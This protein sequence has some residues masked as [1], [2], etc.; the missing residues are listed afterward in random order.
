MNG[1]WL[2]R[3]GNSDPEGPFAAS[4]LRS[5]WSNGIFTDA[6]KL[7]ADGTDEWMPASAIMG[8]IAQEVKPPQPPFSPPSYEQP[9]LVVR[10]AHR[11]ASRETN[12]QSH[13]LTILAIVLILLGTVGLAALGSSALIATAAGIVVMAIAM[14]ARP[15][16]WSCSRCGAVIQKTSRSC[17]TCRAEL[18]FPSTNKRNIILATAALTIGVAATVAL[19]FLASRSWQSPSRDSTFAADYSLKKW[20]RGHYAEQGV[21]LKDFGPPLPWKDYHL[22]LVNI[23]VPKASGDVVVLTLVAEMNRDDSD[24]LYTWTAKEWCKIY[25]T[26]VEAQHTYRDTA[27][28]I[29]KVA[30]SH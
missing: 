6:D 2:S 11:K 4:Q 5:M 16:S 26:S 7:C 20:V 1:Y 21:Q 23:K 14:L 9:E 29:A 15:V 8:E 3:G 22:R 28:Q 24:V 27:E 19:L 12:R 13:L 10:K 30:D 25:R 17:P 18:S